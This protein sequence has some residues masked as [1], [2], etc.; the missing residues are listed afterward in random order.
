MR[1]D[2]YLGKIDVTFVRLGLTDAQ[3]AANG[4]YVRDVLEAELGTRGF[5][6]S[7]KVYAVYYDGTST[8]ACGGGAW[9]PTLVGKVA[10][11]YLKGLPN[12]SV[13]CDANKFTTDVNKPG[14][15][16]FSMLHEA[17]HTIGFVAT[18][19]PNHVLDGHV[20]DD[21]RDLMYAG[22][23]TWRPSIL[24]INRNDYY[25]HYNAGCPDLAKSSY[26]TGVPGT[27]GYLPEAPY[28]TAVRNDLRFPTFKLS[29]HAVPTAYGYYVYVV[30]TAY[31]GRITPVYTTSLTYTTKSL[32]EGGTAYVVAVNK[33]GNSVSSNRVKLS[34]S[35]VIF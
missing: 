22:P 25:G 2:N 13:P 33:N 3:I 23:L 1:V 24:D 31:V 6:Q 27:T 18:C 11:L 5:N 17:V 20:S 8:V 9:P 12:A 28:L 19:A 16:E 10:A 26:V 30:P 35:V 7:N 29:W 32:V 4:I 34:T 21:P 14:Y 15:R